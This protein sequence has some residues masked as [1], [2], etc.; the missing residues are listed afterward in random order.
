MNIDKERYIHIS[1][2]SP[3]AVGIRTNTCD[4]KQNMQY[5][6]CNLRAEESLR[7][8]F[9]KYLTGGRSTTRPTSNEWFQTHTIEQ[10]QH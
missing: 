5:R 9:E 1:G 2:N 7:L 4:K 10:P 3:S 8:K 6:F